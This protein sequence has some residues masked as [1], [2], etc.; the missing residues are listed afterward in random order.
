MNEDAMNVLARIAAES[1]EA[2]CYARVA[3][4]VGYRVMN[5]QRENR[6]SLK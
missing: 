2:F 4:G 3:A 1:G 5:C 6:K